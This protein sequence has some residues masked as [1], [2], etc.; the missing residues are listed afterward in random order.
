M[1]KSNLKGYPEEKDLNEYEILNLKNEAKLSERKRSC[2]II[3]GRGDYQNRV[4]NYLLRDTYMQPHMHPM[5]Y[6]NE[7][8][9]LIHGKLNIYQFDKI[10]SILLVEKLSCKGQAI[11]V[12]S[13]EWH[14]YTVESDYVVTYETMD[15]VYDPRTWKS[16]STWAPRECDKN[17]VQY[18]RALKEEK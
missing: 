12:K 10:G 2:K 14:T 1:P 3:H 4:Y 11:I 15:G 9:M 16:M 5:D 17:A 6:M 7:E 18:L 8:I 13:K